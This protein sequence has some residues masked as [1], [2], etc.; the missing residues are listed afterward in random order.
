MDRIA[1]F[2][3]FSACLGLLN[4]DSEFEAIEQ[5]REQD[6]QMGFVRMIT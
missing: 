6:F 3:A 4:F 2:I 1:W 5:R